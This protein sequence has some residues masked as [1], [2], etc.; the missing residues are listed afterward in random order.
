MSRGFRFQDESVQNEKKYQLSALSTH[1]CDYKYNMT[2]P[3][4]CSVYKQA[5][6]FTLKIQAATSYHLSILLH[7]IIKLSKVLMLLH[8][9]LFLHKDSVSV[10]IGIFIYT[11]EGYINQDLIFTVN[12]HVVGPLTT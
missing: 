6:S 3:Y 1:K 10:C 2:I 11:P 8:N 5:R 7:E 9:I 12:L 4:D